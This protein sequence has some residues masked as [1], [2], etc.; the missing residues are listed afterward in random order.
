MFCSSETATE[1]ATN[2]FGDERAE[3]EGRLS[4]S[5]IRT[6]VG[7]VEEVTMAVVR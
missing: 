1:R 5:A 2:R 3:E 7:E 6:D 4:Q